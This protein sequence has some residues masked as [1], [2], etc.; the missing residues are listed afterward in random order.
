MN[1]LI[2]LSW[3]SILAYDILIWSFAPCLCRFCVWH[4]FIDKLGD[5]VAFYQIGIIL[6]KLFNASR[7]KIGVVIASVNKSTRSCDSVSLV[8]DV[9]DDLFVF[10]VF[11]AMHLRDSLVLVYH[12][13]RQ[14]V[15]LL[16]V[17]RCVVCFVA[18]VNNQVAWFARNSYLVNTCT[19][20]SDG[21][22][23]SLSCLCSTLGHGHQ[24]E[25][26]LFTFFFISIAGSIGSLVWLQKWN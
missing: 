7:E 10:F 19:W 2:S 24:S 11:K 4:C 25:N 9:D 21:S 23:W 14:R 13:Q 12:H 26:A 5:I 20:N 18:Q 22:I 6:D 1:F 17:P 8:I 16:D 3:P 15:T